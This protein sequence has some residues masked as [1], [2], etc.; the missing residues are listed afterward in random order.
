MTNRRGKG[1]DGSLATW[2]R[3][4]A[5]GTLR[6]TSSR[7]TRQSLPAEPGVNR[8]HSRR[9]SVTAEQE[10]GTE[11][12]DR[13]YHDPGLIRAM[14]PFAVDRNTAPQRGDAQ[15]FTIAQV[16]EGAVQPVGVPGCRG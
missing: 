1:P 7:I 16:V 5:N 13:R 15:R 14:G 10:P 11:L 3:V 12:V 6:C 4:S 8:S 9:H 2:A